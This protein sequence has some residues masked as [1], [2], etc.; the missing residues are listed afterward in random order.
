MLVNHVNLWAHMFHH[1][2][3]LQIKPYTSTDID[4]SVASVL[5]SEI[6]NSDSDD[7]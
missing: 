6:D 3:I 1:M 2:V 5:D 4:S 7:N